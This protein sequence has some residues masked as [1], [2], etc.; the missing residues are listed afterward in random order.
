MV[1]SE[2]SGIFISLVRFVVGALLSLMGIII[3]RKN[4]KVHNKF[5]VSM[6]A[7]LGTVAMVLYYVA[8]KY[9]GSGR[10][11]LYNTT[12]PIFVA[13]FSALLFKEKLKINNFISIALCIVGVYFVLYDGSRTDIR[14][15]ILGILSGVIGGLSYAY[16]KRARETDHTLNI[17]MWIC[18]CGVSMTFYTAGEVNR[19]E[20]F[21]IIILISSAITVFLAQVFITY[22]TKFVAVVKGSII[23]FF[24]IPITMGLSL[25]FLGE[26]FKFKFIIGTL[27]ILSGLIINRR[28]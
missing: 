19:I 2:F 27:F 10:A 26:T 1:S 4:L 20:P 12:Y 5:A 13:I 21:S 16:S 25:V 18:L 14:G 7:F 15:D 9:S 17:Y 22:G 24:R 3:L 8:I 23:S 6:R 11:T 28:Q